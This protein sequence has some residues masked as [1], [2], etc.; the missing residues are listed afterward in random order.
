MKAIELLGNID[1][2]NHLS[3]QVPAGLPAGP[4]R[5]IV[6]LPE[7]E[8]AGA[9]WADRIAREWSKALGDSQEDIYTLQDGRPL[10][11]PQ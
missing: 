3:A 1:D 9:S 5:L 4:V 11:A 8:E 2:Q 10:D 6:L 7:Q